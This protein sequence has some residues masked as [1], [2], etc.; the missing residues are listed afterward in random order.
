M[1]TSHF[2]LEKCQA[3]LDNQMFLIDSHELA[4]Q[5]ALGWKNPPQATEETEEMQVRSLAWE[6]PVEEDVAA[7]SSIL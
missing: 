6:G 1:H 4:S 5:V 2:L 7:H 3:S